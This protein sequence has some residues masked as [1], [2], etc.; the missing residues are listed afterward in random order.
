MSKKTVLKTT[1][2]LSSTVNE[3]VEVRNDD[4][5]SCFHTILAKELLHLN[6]K[7][8]TDIITLDLDIRIKHLS[9]RMRCVL[10]EC[11]CQYMKIWPGWGRG[12]N[13]STEKEIEEYFK[14]FEEYLRFKLNYIIENEKKFWGVPVINKVL[15][16]KF[17]SKEIQTDTYEND[18]KQEAPYNLV[19]SGQPNLLGN[20]VFVEMN[21]EYT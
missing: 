20:I 13:D 18:S 15:C 19:I 7:K 16:E 3:V 5:K 17:E 10:A 2:I 9:H 4:L 11:L 21:S 12:V 8:V 1:P 6:A 14:K